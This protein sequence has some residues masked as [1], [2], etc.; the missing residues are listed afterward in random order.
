MIISIGNDKILICQYLKIEEKKPICHY[1][2]IGR[3]Y[4]F[5]DGEKAPPFDVILRSNVI[6]T[7]IT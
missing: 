7:K 6:K 5:I 2:K 4:C 3:N 1:A